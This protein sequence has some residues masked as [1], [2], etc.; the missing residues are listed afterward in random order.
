MHGQDRSLGGDA[1]HDTP[2]EQP[3]QAPPH[4]LKDAGVDGPPRIQLYDV[5]ALD[6][7]LTRLS[8]VI[9]GDSA[10][11]PTVRGNEWKS[12]GNSRTPAKAP[13]RDPG[14]PRGTVYRE[15]LSAAL[16]ARPRRTTRSA[17]GARGTRTPDPLGA[18]PAGSQRRV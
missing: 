7:P 8:C 17:S 9:A 1:A 18:M 13:A 14:P 11:A 2:A 6:H 5:A 10:N 16:A 15:R 12:K 3:A 4:V